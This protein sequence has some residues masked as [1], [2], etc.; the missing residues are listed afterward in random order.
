MCLDGAKTRALLGAKTCAL[1]GAK[2]CALLGARTC[3]LVRAKT[4]EA[5][6][7]TWGA[8]GTHPGS[9]W[10]ALGG[11]DLWL[12]EHP[13]RG[14]ADSSVAP[15]QQ[16][17]VTKRCLGTRKEPPEALQAKPIWGI[18]SVATTLRILPI[19]NENQMGRQIPSTGLLVRGVL[20]LLW[21]PHLASWSIACLRC[22][23]AMS[24]PRFPNA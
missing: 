7:G 13:G 18:S 23:I 1:V 10:E 9:I 5:S 15:P 2:T 8:P 14:M 11:V 12:P 6:R 24:S 17:G 20:G 3:A 21:L 19:Q 16:S 4:W 22:T